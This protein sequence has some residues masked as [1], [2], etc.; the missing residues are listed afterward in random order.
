MS[1]SGKTPL[2]FPIPPMLA[3]SVEQP[4][5]SDQYLFE[6]KWDGF[7]ALAYITAGNT[8]IFSRNQ[9]EMTAQFPELAFLHR[10][11]AASS[12]II[13]GEIVAFV[14]GKPSFHSLLSRSKGARLPKTVR[15]WVHRA[16]VTFLA[17]DILFLNGTS[18]MEMPLTL[19]KESLTRVLEQNDT[20][21]LSRHVLTHGIALYEAV[22]S[23]GLEG[24][25]AKKL[26]SRYLP[27]KRSRDWLKCKV[28][29]TA[30]AC[31]IGFTPKG[32]ELASLALAVYKEHT[33]Y[34]IG[35]VGTGFSTGEAAAMRRFFE[36]FT[37]PLSELAV[38]N[39]DPAVIQ[40]T[41]WVKPQTVCEVRYLELTPDH[42]LRHPSFVRI[43]P[44][45]GPEDCTWDQ[46]TR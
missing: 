39:V 20:A 10:Q 28:I 16:P 33:L 8:R 30:E 44:D 1:E 31:I 6:P 42:R 7:R 9:R 14:D 18:L 3:H 40:T 22:Q 36:R 37:I 32:R 45:K 11:V 41:Q 26:D 38:D 34:Y 24:I 35:H 29:R 25:M 17:F 5:D 15:D 12:A 21:L 23:Q 27:G 43:R 4:F 2:P 13:D 19:R 46:F